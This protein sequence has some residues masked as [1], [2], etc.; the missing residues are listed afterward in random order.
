MSVA[1]LVVHLLSFVTL[2][3]IGPIQRGNVTEPG[4]L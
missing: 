1:Y 3:C 2:E 4:M